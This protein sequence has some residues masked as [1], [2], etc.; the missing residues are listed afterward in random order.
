MLKLH[1][2]ATILFYPFPSTI[3]IMKTSTSRRKFLTNT[4]QGLVVGTALTTGTFMETNAHTPAKLPAF[5]HH[6]FFWLK[7]PQ[8]Q[9]AYQQLYKALQKLGQITEI[10]AAHIGRS[11]INDFD[12]SVTDAS[13]TFSVLLLFATKE[14]EEKYLVHPLHKQFIEENKHLWSKVVVYDSIAIR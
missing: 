9:E 6:V 8:N 7:E 2:S 13:Y 11:S 1:L 14:A 4:A 3:M 10:A 12:K 5:S